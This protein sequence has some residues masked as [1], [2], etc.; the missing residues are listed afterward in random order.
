MPWHARLAVDYTLEAGRTVARHRHEGPLR[1]LQSLYPE[2]D[3]SCHNVLIHP[4]G[5]LVGGDTLEINLHAGPGSHALITTPG[6]SRFYRSD[7]AWARQLTRIRLDSAARLEWLPLESLAYPGCLAENRLQ[8]DLAPEAEFIGWD[9]TAL[10]LPDAGQ[11]F[12]TG[13]WQ[14]HIECGGHWLERGL[15][16]ATDHR[17]LRSPLGL[18]G[19]ACLASLFFLSGS[20]LPRDRRE[21]LLETARATLR[22]EGAPHPVGV[23]SP[24][25]RVVVL[26]A[27]GERVE[28]CSALLRRVWAAWRASQWQVGTRAPRLWSL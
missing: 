23:T 2:G 27:L 26:R 21:A 6:A 14:Q 20:A 22:A 1:L 13:R 3:A 15:I 16:D 17:L 28:P 24:N 10:G 25:P 19:M 18:N 4:P 7:G 11:P 12:E 8:L 5:G 9:I